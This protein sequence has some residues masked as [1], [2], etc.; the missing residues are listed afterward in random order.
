MELEHKRRVGLVSVHVRYHVTRM[1]S[2]CGF[3][4]TFFLGTY[5]VAQLVQL[6]AENGKP[7]TNPRV[8]TW[9]FCQVTPHTFDSL[10]TQQWVDVGESQARILFDE[11]FKN[12]AFPPTRSIDN[13][14]RST[15]GQ[16]PITAEVV[17]PGSNSAFSL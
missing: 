12:C 4:S 3:E 11:N 6:P 13:P 16:W 9:N 5:L 17:S 14:A 15:V 2:S 1:K 10:G 7:E 8:T